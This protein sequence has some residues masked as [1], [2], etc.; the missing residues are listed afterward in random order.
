[1]EASMSD[2]RMTPKQ[3]A[4]AQKRAIEGWRKTGT[5]RTHRLGNT[6]I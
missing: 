2:I 3:A 6:Q 5:V 4:A 1:M